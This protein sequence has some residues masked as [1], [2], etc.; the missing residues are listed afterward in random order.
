LSSAGPCTPYFFGSAE[1]A[2]ADA[3]GDALTETDALGVTGAVLAVACAAGASSWPAQA[4]TPIRKTNAVFMSFSIYWQVENTNSAVVRFR[5]TVSA[6]FEPSR[7]A[8]RC[9]AFESRSADEQ[10]RVDG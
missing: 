6:R 10:A 7:A 3:L 9:A 8:G 2:V 4:P 5:R 1:L